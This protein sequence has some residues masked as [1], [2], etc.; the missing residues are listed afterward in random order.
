MRWLSTSL[1][2]PAP[3]H[4]CGDSLC[5]YEYILRSARGATIFYCVVAFLIIFSLGSTIGSAARNELMFLNLA[6]RTLALFPLLFVLG[7]ALQVAVG[8]SSVLYYKLGA[9]D[10]FWFRAA[11]DKHCDAA[12]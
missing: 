2:A 5:A 10:E 12:G 9:A 8:S 7:T 3:V 4:R 11:A 6:W 1:H